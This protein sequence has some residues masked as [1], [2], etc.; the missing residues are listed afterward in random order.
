MQPGPRPREA[1]GGCPAATLDEPPA[2]VCAPLLPQPAFLA[3]PWNKHDKSAEN[4]KSPPEAWLPGG[5]AVPAP[6]DQR[7]LNTRRRSAQFS[8]DNATCHQQLG[9]SNNHD[10]FIQ[11]VSAPLPLVRS[12]LFSIRGEYNACAPNELLPT[13]INRINSSSSRSADGREVFLP[14][15]EE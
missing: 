6:R 2:L 9:I 12:L 4:K 7:P 10:Q 5:V 8:T 3:A 14:R 11:S 13:Q 15:A 1:S